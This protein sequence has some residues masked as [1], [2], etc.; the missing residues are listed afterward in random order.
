M[1]TA[2][3]SSAIILYPSRTLLRFKLQAYESRSSN[4]SSCYY[5]WVICIY[6]LSILPDYLIGYIDEKSTCL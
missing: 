1:N 4:S 6:L 5:I 2:L 3:A